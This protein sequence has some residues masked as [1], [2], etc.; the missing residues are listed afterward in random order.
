MGKTCEADKRKD[1]FGVIV[2]VL[3]KHGK[4]ILALDGKE[5]CITSKEAIPLKF[6]D[7]SKKEKRITV[8]W[9]AVVC[10]LKA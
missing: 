10:R 1:K 2:H 3:K 4:H 6:F 9:W 7:I 5:K 8:A